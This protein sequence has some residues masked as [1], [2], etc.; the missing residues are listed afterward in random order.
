MSENKQQRFQRL[1]MNRVNKAIKSIELIG[2]LG[3]K[4]LYE[5]TQDER[6]KIIKA[7]NDSVA[8]MKIDL[9]GNSKKR[10]GFKFD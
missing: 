3:N 10:E 5:S 8:Q 2:N 4:S 9:D 7:I 6:K 1:A